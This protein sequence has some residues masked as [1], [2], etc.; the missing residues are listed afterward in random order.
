MMA[1]VSSS[2]KHMADREIYL[3]EDRYSRPKEYFKL[4]HRELVR[5]VHKPTAVVDVGCA[6]GELLYFLRK[7]LPKDCLLTGV[8]VIPDLIERARMKVADVDFHIADISS[9]DLPELPQY[10]AVIFAGVLGHIFTPD[11]VVKNL[12]SLA[13]K[14]GYIYIFAP[15]NEESID[16][17]LVYKRPTESGEWET[18][19]NLYSMET[20]ESLVADV[21]GEAEWIDFFM[22]FEITKTDDV[23]RGWTE[24]FRGENYMMYGT[25][26]FASQKL[27]KIKLGA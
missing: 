23:M 17:Q 14:G 6:A 25:N 24:K 20:M 16:V 10:D 26:Q 18:G 1:E 12:E 15:F 4:I 19:R 5:D 13:K 11:I 9:T 3:N 7:Q 27:L 8:D 22:P 21:G 2:E